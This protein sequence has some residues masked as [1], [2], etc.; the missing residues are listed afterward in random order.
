M[1]DWLSLFSALII[2]GCF[3]VLARFIVRLG[4]MERE[5]ILNVLNPPRMDIPSEPMIGVKN[6]FVLELKSA[7][8]SIDEMGNIAVQTWISSIILFI[9]SS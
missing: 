6:P 5:A 9:S 8:S 4:A 7:Q 1:A 3:L 2:V